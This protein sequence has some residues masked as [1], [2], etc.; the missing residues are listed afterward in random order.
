MRTLLADWG[1][2]KSCTRRE[3]ELL[4]GHLS[5]ACKVIRPGRSFLRRMIELLHHNENAQHVRLNRNF[6]SDLQWWKA[7]ATSWNSISYLHGN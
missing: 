4:I 6:R 2:K 3:L 1:D 5:H 7:F